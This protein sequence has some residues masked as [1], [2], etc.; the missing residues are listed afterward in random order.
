MNFTCFVIIINILHISIV[1]III[2]TNY[3]IHLCNVSLSFGPVSSSIII[4]RVCSI[5]IF[6]IVI[7]DNDVHIVPTLP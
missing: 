2:M 3:V 6:I 7:F 5:V 1:Y 4:R